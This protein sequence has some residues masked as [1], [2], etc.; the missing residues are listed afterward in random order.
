MKRLLCAIAI[1]F[2]CFIFF[3]CQT[4]PNV[5]VAAT[6]LPVYEFS[7]T[8]CNGTD[9][10]VGRIITENVTCLHDYTLQT[11]QMRIIENAQI[12]VISGAGLEDF[13]SDVMPDSNA[14]IDASESIELLCN[15]SIHEHS[16]DSQ[17]HHEHDPHIWLSPANAS[18]MAKNIC[19]GLEKA[20]PQ[21][22]EQFRA[23]LKLLLNDL[24]ALEEYGT[25]QL[26]TLSNRNLITFHD[27]FAYLAN[28]FDLEILKAIEEE[29]GSEA[30]A[31]ELIETC[32]LIASYDLP[33]I[34]TEQNGS[35]PAAEVIS[36]ETGVSVYQLDMAMTGNGYLNAMYN[37]ID[38]LK[39]ALE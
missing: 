4:E 22:T 16:H 1:A 5:Q 17:D 33:A 13:L 38:T 28:A 10:S 37:N 31:S 23:N 9:I 24:A 18:Q 21:Y 14:V 7:K 12:V 19:E 34:F 20:Y 36:L 39:E 15:T 30:S 32:Q 2:L 11:S 29:S 8:I 3:G 26:K 35:V 6:T 27:G 25:Q